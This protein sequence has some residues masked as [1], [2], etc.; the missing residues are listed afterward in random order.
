MKG[1]CKNKKQKQ[2]KQPNKQI[3]KN[4]KNGDGGYRKRMRDE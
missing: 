4:Q 3:K 1:K 2:K